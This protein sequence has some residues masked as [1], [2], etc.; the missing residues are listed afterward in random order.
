MPIVVTC[1]CGL[2]LSIDRRSIGREV[3]CPECRAL[4]QVRSRGG[5][6]ELVPIEDERS[7]ARPEREPR[8]EG[9]QQASSPRVPKRTVIRGKS[10]FALEAPAIG[11]FL[12]VIAIVI[13]IGVVMYPRA[14]LNG[15]VVF[16]LCAMIVGVAFAVFCFVGFKNP[17]LLLDDEYL[18]MRIG[19]RETVGQLPI[20]NIA[21]VESEKRV[22]HTRDGTVTWFV[23]IIHLIDSRDRDT[24]WPGF[25][26]HK[27][28]SIEIEDRYMKSLSW[29][30]GRIGTKVERHRESRRQ[31][32][33]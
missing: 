8:P 5:S 16:F 3:R 17:R 21:G 2:G 22:E 23:L 18:E 32:G 4:F 19:R 1:P 10:A 13:L 33:R 15:I 20:E 12:G 6:P 31:G 29:I 27:G 7:S 9:R 26:G 25:G 24:W 11:V 14:A 30:S 28:E